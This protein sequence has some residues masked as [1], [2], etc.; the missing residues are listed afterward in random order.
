MLAVDYAPHSD[1]FARAS[2]I[3]H[4]GGI[5][6]TAQ[7][8]RS[9]RPSLIV[10]FSHDQPDNAWRCAHLGVARVLQ[11]HAPRASVM[12]RELGTLLGD[13]AMRERAARVGAR[14]R[15]E[16][17]TRTAVDAILAALGR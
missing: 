9:G 4:Q 2:A 8:L 11:R 15:A 17:G 1:L 7:A 12:E 10:P 5:G 14:V 13:S 3:V 6:T 16:H